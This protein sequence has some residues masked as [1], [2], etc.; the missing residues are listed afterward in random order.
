MIRKLEC[1]CIY[2]SD[3]EASAAFYS[4]LGLTESWRLD[5]NTEAGDPCL[6]IGFRFPDSNSSELVISNNPDRQFSEIELLVDD[7]RATFDELC[8]NAA[9]T[10]RRKP[11]PIPNGHVAVMTAPD[12]N[13]FVL[14]GN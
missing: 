6:L 7:V 11:S 5:R 12:G 3:I 8:T 2:T 10:W 4:S 14:I 9:I 1:T 13:D